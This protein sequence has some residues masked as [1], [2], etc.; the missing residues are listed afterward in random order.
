MR[1]LKISL[2]KIG[3]YEFE[4]KI[5][6]GQLFVHEMGQLGINPKSPE[7]NIPEEINVSGNFDVSW[8]HEIPLVV[9]E[10]LYAIHKDKDLE[11][12]IDFIDLTKLCEE[13]EQSGHDEDWKVDLLAKMGDRQYDTLMDK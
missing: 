4:G 2:T 10:E 13:I 1:E 3:Q 8:D 9:I 7:E 5:T 11:F 6:S 12:N